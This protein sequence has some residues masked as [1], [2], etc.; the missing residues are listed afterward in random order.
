[1][2][3]KPLKQPDW[4]APEHALAAADDFLHGPAGDP[5]LALLSGRSLDALCATAL[6]LRAL[7]DLGR[8][9]DA[10]WIEGPDFRATRSAT[11]RAW[12]SLEPS[13][14]VACGLYAPLTPSSRLPPAL[15]LVGRST[16]DSGRIGGEVLDVRAHRPELPLSLLTWFLLERSVVHPEREWLAVLGTLRVLGPEAPIPGFVDALKRHGRVP[17]TETMGLVHAA[18]HAADFD[19]QRVLEMLLGTRKPLDLSL[20]RAPH[21]ATLRAQRDTVQEALEEALLRPAHRTPSVLLCVLDSPHAL[22]PLVA[23]RLAY[24]EPGVAV[25]VLNLGLDRRRVMLSIRSRASLSP[26]VLS[27]V[28]HLEGLRVLTRRRSGVE[29]VF[30]RRELPLLFER[31]GLRGETS[32]VAPVLGT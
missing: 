29:A 3:L 25:L 21:V 28:L 6:W 32:G 23:A 16:G 7:E 10:T 13:A 11:S 30:D 24:Q 27:D 31:L 26:R 12:R 14:L 8:A 15:S 1:M 4:P 9:P 22:S 19:P 5:G 20:G 17:L 2:A 18:S